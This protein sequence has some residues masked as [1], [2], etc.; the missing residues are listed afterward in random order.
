MTRGLNGENSILL[1]KG[2]RSDPLTKT[3]YRYLKLSEED[4]NHILLLGPSGFGKTTV[5]KALAQEIYLN[6]KWGRDR[7]PP[8]II[9]FE[10]KYDRGKAQLL[11]KVYYEL[12]ARWGESGLAARL[13][14]LSDIKLYI[15]LLEH[16]AFSGKVGL[17]GDFAL[18]WENLLAYQYLD[19][20]HTLFGHFGMRPLALPHRRFVFNPTR[21]LNHIALDSGPL[22]EVIATFIKYSRLDF[23]DIAKILSMNTNTIYA[24]LIKEA[25]DNLR[26]RDP[27]GVV[28]R[29]KRIYEEMLEFLEVEKGKRKPSISLWGV[30]ST[31]QYLKSNKVFGRDS[32]GK[33][34]LDMIDNDKINVIDF[35]Q[36]S[37]LTEEEKKIIFKKVVEWAL[38]EY[39]K[40]KETAVFIFADEVQNYL[41]DRWGKRIV[42]KLF[43]E[44]RSNQVNLIVATQYLHSLPSEMAYGASHIAV[45]GMLASADDYNLI[46]KIVGDF[47]IKY[48]RVVASTAAEAAVL[49]KKHRGKGWFIWDKMFTE[50]IHFR[51]S[52]T[53]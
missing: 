12:L 35:S 30:K 40:K 52:Q 32:R 18:S 31:M 5:M 39:A 42:K 37:L 49:K 14:Q 25:W 13:T 46:R 2:M 50:R 11:K 44:G 19:K 47:D 23:E 7:E 24:Q 34:L 15:N 3:A 26:V 10:R 53:L 16:P 36:N 1:G 48:E 27:D 33:D 22:T 17:M 21:Q 41:D 51:P 20:H 8:L 28:L 45:V 43:R 29:A 6:T 38:N 9:I 4:A